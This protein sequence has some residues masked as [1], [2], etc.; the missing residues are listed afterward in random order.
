MPLPDFGLSTGFMPVGAPIHAPPTSA[1][2]DRSSQLWRAE[3]EANLASIVRERDPWGFI[4]MRPD[5]DV[6][7][8]DASPDG[9]KLCSVWAVEVRL[10]YPVRALPLAALLA[11]L[12][13]WWESDEPGESGYLSPA[14]RKFDDAARAFYAATDAADRRR[15]TGSDG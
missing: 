5:C 10:L 4:G 14:D 8:F 15:L 7:L 9:I 1:K 2:L 6:A 12:D 11:A 13:E 3:W